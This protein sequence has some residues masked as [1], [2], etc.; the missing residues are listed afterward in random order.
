M[1]PRTISGEHPICEQNPACTKSF[2][3]VERRL[4]KLEDFGWVESIRSDIKSLDR[5]VANLNGRLS[6]YVI[7]GGLLGAALTFVAQRVFK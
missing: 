3:E 7:A 6:G 1:G 5:A 2:I 4:T